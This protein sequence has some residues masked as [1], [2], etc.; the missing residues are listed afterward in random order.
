M[1]KEELIF[2]RAKLRG[3]IVEKFGMYKTFA[4]ALGIPASVVNRKLNNLI[5][6]TQE[7]VVRWSKLLEL[8]PEEIGPVFFTLEVPLK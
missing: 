2:S 3:K 1:A 8:A 4:D 6:I 7:D 5:G